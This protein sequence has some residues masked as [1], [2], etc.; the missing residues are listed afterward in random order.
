MLPWPQSGNVIM[1]IQRIDSLV[2][3][4]NGKARALHML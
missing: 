4:I 1:T 3:H 2:S